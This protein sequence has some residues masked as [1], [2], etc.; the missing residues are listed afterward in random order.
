MHRSPSRR[1]QTLAFAVALSAMAP[2]AWAQDLDDLDEGVVMET[3]FEAGV[4]PSVWEISMQ[5]G[6]LNLDQVLL[7]ANGIVVDVE[8]PSDVIFASMDLR[9]ELSFSPHIRV[10]RTFGNHFAIENTF[11]F[12]IGNF[13]QSVS[14]DQVKWT[15]N[16]QISNNTLTEQ[17]IEAGSY[18]MWLHEHSVAYYP[19]G[20]GRIQP[21]LTAGIGSQ[22][23][24]VDSD[25]IDGGSTSLGISYGG[26]LR[27]VGDDLYSFRIEVRNYHSTVSFDTNEQFRPDQVNLTGDGIVGF[28]VS[29]L[30]E[31]ASLT[32][33][34][35]ATAERL[36]EQLELDQIQD[37]DQQLLV[38][39]PIESYEDQSLA[40]LW[41]SLGFV[42]AF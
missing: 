17:E 7:S 22:H 34:E 12:A 19:R 13:Q 29:H 5:I 24:Y 30:R 11:G 25:Y 18:F 3:P 26:G 16:E 40:S 14:D 39:M 28:P 35:R 36:W 33:E 27:V 31:L 4:E 15:F 9:G 41:V 21:Y 10:N 42:A 6:Y 8:N 20:E 23:L 38:P 1:V 2:T 32:P 37:I